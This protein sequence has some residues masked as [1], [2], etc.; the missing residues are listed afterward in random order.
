MVS[1]EDDGTGNC[2]RFHEIRIE[3]PFIRESFIF[4][5]EHK[6]IDICKV[7]SRC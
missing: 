3:N 5:R 1:K 6:Y 4:D 7:R 2:S